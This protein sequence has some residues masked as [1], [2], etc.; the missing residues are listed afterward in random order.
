MPM[1]V[2]VKGHRMLILSHDEE[3]LQVGLEKI[4]ADGIE[5][6]VIG[7]TEEEQINTMHRLA[8]SVGGGVVVAPLNVKIE[9][10]VD[11]LSQQLP[12]IH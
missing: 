4:G 7:E 2:T 10:V 3:A 12:W 6:I 5:A 1:A 11:S 8:K 9:D